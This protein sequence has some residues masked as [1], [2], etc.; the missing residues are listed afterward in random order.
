MKKRTKLALL[1]IA[2]A[3][4]FLTR[5]SS[6]RPD[7]VGNMNLADCP[8]TPNCVSTLELDENQRIPS[9][10]YTGKAS[11]AM[12]KLIKILNSTPRTTIVKRTDSYIYAECKTLFFRFIDDVE[13]IIDDEKKVINFRSASRVGKSDLGVNRERMEKIAARFS[14]E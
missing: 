13:F 10:P 7:N 6:T 2:A 1:S 9:I 14:V 8:N 5:C 11:D 4:F 12:T 3:S